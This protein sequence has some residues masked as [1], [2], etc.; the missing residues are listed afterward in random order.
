MEARLAKEKERKN[1]I[2]SFCESGLRAASL[3][4]CARSYCELLA[5]VAEDG[6]SDRCMPQSRLKCDADVGMA[7]NGKENTRK[8]K[9]KRMR[10]DDFLKKNERGGDERRQTS[11]AI[12]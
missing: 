12:A 7:Q 5:G 1:Q 11:L 9:P 8:K 6:Q 2:L 10:A 3:V 4:V